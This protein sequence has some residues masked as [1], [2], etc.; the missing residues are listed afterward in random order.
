MPSV[1]CVLERIVPIEKVL[2]YV[3]LRLENT[4]AGGELSM[5]ELPLALAGH[6]GFAAS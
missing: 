1:T 5:L 3:E 2:L 6:E 4:K